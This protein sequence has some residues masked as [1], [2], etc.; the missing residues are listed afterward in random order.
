MQFDQSE[1]SS[2]LVNSIGQLKEALGGNLSDTAAT[3]Y[4]GMIGGMAARINR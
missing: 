2:V 3:L 4:Q 1:E